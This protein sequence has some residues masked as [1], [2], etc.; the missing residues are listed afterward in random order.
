[1]KLNI[2]NENIINCQKLIYV[3]NDKLISLNYFDID[4]ETLDLPRNINLKFLDCF[5]AKQKK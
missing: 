1:M 2:N 5:F 4:I 3:A